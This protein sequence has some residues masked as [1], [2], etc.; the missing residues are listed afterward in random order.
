MFWLQ[1]RWG[2][3]QWTLTTQLEC[4]VGVLHWWAGS[5]LP[6][7]APIMWNPLAEFQRYSMSGFVAAMLSPSMSSV[8]QSVYPGCSLVQAANWLTLSFV[9]PTIPT[10]G[11]W[12]SHSHLYPTD[13]L[14]QF[15]GIL[16][17][18]F[19]ASSGHPTELYASHPC[20]PSPS[21]L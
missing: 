15:C 11:L 17:L 21:F 19:C 1:S 14:N 13:H 4:L 8:P 12:C 16:T 10:R 2:P 5:E 7:Y 6:E 3:F 9:A 18:S 20:T